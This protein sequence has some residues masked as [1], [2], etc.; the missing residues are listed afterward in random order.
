[1]IWDVVKALYL[2]QELKLEPSQLDVD[3]YAEVLGV[4][5][6]KDQDCHSFFCHV[7]NKYIKNNYDEID[8]TRPVIIVEY[9]IGKGKEKQLTKTL[10]DGRHRLRKA[11]AERVEELPC[12]VIKDDHEKLI[13]LR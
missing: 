9:Y 11:Y 5:K 7:D 13:R 4:A 1:M 6:P 2:I 8:L 3:S 10:L 12:Y